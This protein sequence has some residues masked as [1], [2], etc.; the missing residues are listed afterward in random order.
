LE[1]DWL[2]SLNESAGKYQEKFGKHRKEL[3][4]Q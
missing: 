1:E 3:K 2:I 4:K